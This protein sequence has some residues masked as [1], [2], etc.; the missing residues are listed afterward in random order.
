[1]ADDDSDSAGYAH[2]NFSFTMHCYR[3]NGSE[4]EFEAP[5]CYSIYEF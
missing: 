2:E 5:S 1:M 4:K 3:E